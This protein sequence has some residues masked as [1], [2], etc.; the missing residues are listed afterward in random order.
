EPDLPPLEID[1]AWVEEIRGRLPE[2]EPARRTR[3]Q[4]EYGLSAYDAALLTSAR[5]TADYFEAVV[6]AWPADSDRKSFA[7]EAANWIS[8]ELTRL[9]NENAE[10]VSD[11]AK[12]KVAPARLAKLVALF[13][14]RNL[15]N[16]AAKQVLA[17]MFQSGRDPEQIVEEKGLRKVSDTGS[18]EPAVEQAIAGNPAAVE[19]YL[20]GKEAAV[21]FLVGQVMRASRGRADPE[22]AADLITRKL[23][24]LRK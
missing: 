9:M 24:A 13:Q 12:T 6:A 1:P 3:F 20:K 10:P 5:E 23:Q 4:A 2:L 16:A 22:V 17:E 19:D 18:L 8:G 15:S 7:K 11:P 21:R 14:A